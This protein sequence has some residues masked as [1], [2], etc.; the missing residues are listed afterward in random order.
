MKQRHTI[1]DEEHEKL[2]EI[3][4]SFWIKFGELAAE[5][6]QMMPKDLEDLTAAHI[7]DLCSVYGSKCFDLIRQCDSK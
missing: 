6:I 4:N 1:T 7:Q 5:H 2:V 3:G